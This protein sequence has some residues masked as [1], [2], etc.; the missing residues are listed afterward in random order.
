M[1]T[2]AVR[3]CEDS[4]HCATQNVPDDF[5]LADQ[6]ALQQATHNA[7]GE[8][9]Q[10]GIA[11]EFHATPTDF[12]EHAGSHTPVAVQAPVH[13]NTA[14]SWNEQELLGCL[15]PGGRH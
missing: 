12:D 6:D 15:E 10:S 8:T 13:R 3:W 9:W 5:D 4:H 2:I 14:D 7:T 1:K 11:F